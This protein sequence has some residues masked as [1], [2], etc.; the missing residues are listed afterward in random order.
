MEK[1]EA[2]NIAIQSAMISH[3][4]FYAKKG[5]ESEP[6]NSPQV[7]LESLSTLMNLARLY[8]LQD[9]ESEKALTKKIFEVIDSDLQGR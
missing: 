6:V 7:T 3:K 2:L 5:L 9:A 8:E 4:E 1:N